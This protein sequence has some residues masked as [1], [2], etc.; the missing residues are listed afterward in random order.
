MIIMLDRPV[1]VRDGEVKI[2][3]TN[4]WISLKRETR[5]IR[6]SAGDGVTSISR[7]HDDASHCAQDDIEI[8][9]Q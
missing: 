5:R 4:S 8:E 3:A 9:Q 6:P 1:L 7:A 2:D